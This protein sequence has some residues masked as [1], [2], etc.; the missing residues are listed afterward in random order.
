MEQQQIFNINPKFDKTA[1]LFITT[2]E[3][4]IEPSTVHIYINTLKNLIRYITTQ[5]PEI[6]KLSELKRSPHIENWLTHLITIGNCKATRQLKI[7][8]ARRFFHLIYEWGWDDAPEPGL[9][10]LK[11]FPRLDKYSPRPIS[12]EMDKKLM[13]YLRSKKTPVD[14]ALL[15]LRKTGMRIGELRIMELDCLEKLPNGNY[16][17]KVPLGKLH[18]D[19]KIPVDQ[20]SVKIINHI[21][22]LRENC[23]P[24]PHPR[25]GKPTQFLLT[26]F[27]GKTYSYAGLR[28]S[29]VTAVEKSGIQTHITP[30]QCRHTFATELLRADI[31]LVVL[32]KLL[33]HKDIRMTLRYA[34]IFNPDIQRAY[35][36]A[37]EKINSIRVLLKSP[38]NTPFNTD[39]KTDSDYL[40]EELCNMITKIESVHKD[41]IDMENKKK[42]QRIIERLR[43]VKQDI[44]NTIQ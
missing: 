2:I 15:L 3:T 29:F 1:Q 25:T 7:M 41:T 5:Y 38:Q 42:I 27:N 19:R 26:H 16:I 10:T 6:N 43:R 24:T 39:E 32:M 22:K 14:K 13:G 40:K 18:T 36:S 33:G 8:N 35:Y 4:T 11:D 44:E 12:A 34:A 37:I 21:I 30:H 20:E 23:L 31:N 28:K 17:L 9:I